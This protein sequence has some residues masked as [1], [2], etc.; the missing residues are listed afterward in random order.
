MGNSTQPIFLQG[1]SQQAARAGGFDVDAARKAGYSDDEI[2]QHLTQTRNF[3]IAGA[4]KAGYSTADIIQHLSTTP[5]PASY[6]NL[7]PAGATISAP[8]KSTGMLNDAE[9]WFRDAGN[10]VRYGT[11]VTFLGRGLQAMGAKGTNYGNSEAVGD[12]IGSPVLGTL[13]AA[14]GTAEL[15]QSGKTWQGTKDVVGGAAQ[16]ATIPSFFMG[17]PAVE[18]TAAATGAAASKVFGS[19]EKAGQLFNEVK[20][21]AGSSPVPV[22]DEM[23][24][25]ASRAMDL[26]D[27]GAKGLPRVISKFMN[28]VTNPGKTPVLWDEA[29]NFYSNVSRLSANEYASMNPQMQA[30]VGKFA[31]AFNDALQATAEAAGKG[32]EYA[33]AMQLYA[34][35]KSWQR[36][37]SEAWQFVK[38][39]APYAAGVGAG[40]RMALA[41][42]DKMIP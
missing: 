37:G 36:F 2:L 21:A 6:S 41:G 19:V 9:N 35:A 10:D 28:R 5:S 15:P 27:T 42:L 12:F 7:I 40:G 31:G 20:A 13:R 17:G 26:A 4:Q 33:Q 29:R 16:A 30:A 23:Y 24:T 32:D 8:P 34:R 38:K 18:G 14:Q 25:A 22:S 1:N 39:A 11:G 3:D